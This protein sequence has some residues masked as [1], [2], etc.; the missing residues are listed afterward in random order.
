MIAIVL[1]A[2]EWALELDDRDRNTNRRNKQEKNKQ[3]KIKKWNDFGFFVWNLK[4][5]KTEKNK[6][7]LKLL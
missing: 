5:K 2:K 1:G 4:W 6:Y 7:F 3:N